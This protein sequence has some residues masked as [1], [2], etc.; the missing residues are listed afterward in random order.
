MSNKRGLLV[1]IT[2]PSGSG[3]TSIYKRLLQI[4]DDMKFSVSYTTRKQR[5]GEINGIDY[6]FILRDEFEEK[7]KKGDFLE[8]AEVH[9]ELYGTE[10]SQV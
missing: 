8:W 4:R 5:K 3:K 2:A 10:K 9:G 7:I 6:F 1:V